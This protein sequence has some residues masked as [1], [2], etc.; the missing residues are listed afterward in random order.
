MDLSDQRR[1][2]AFQVVR[3]TLW[4]VLAGGCGG[5]LFALLVDPP[6]GTGREVDVLRM[7]L[8]AIVPI[9]AAL[10]IVLLSRGLLVPAVGVFALIAYAVPM[11][12]AIVFGLGIHSIGIVLWPAVIML[13]G[14]ALGYA[15][16]IA[17]TALFVASIGGLL[18]A[19]AA[20]VLPAPTPAALGS[21][22]YSA[23]ILFFVLGLVCW[24]TIRYSRIFF[25]A[26]QTAAA[27]RQELAS[28]NL[29]L[30]EQEEFFRLIAENV[31]DFIAVL[32]LE[33]RRIYVSPSYHEFIGEQDLRGSD[34]FAQIHPQDRERVRQVFLET[35]H[36]GIGHRL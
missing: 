13:L 16:A 5:L 11:V 33:G 34:S 28:N 32:D 10:G 15:A 22:L 18:V 27:T 31:G 30:R 2:I 19:Q 7:S 9:A 17:I 1:Q 8:A 14:F 35:V 25:E 23:L 29:S 20:A 3:V 4:I 36:T 24:L 6:S 21:P 12:S 26:L